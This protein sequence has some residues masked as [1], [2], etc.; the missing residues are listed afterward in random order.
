VWPY[1]ELH[2]A[3]KTPTT[4]FEE[5][6]RLAA[7]AALVGELDAVNVRY[8]TALHLAVIVD[9]P[10]VV[11]QLVARGAS[12][13]RQEQRH[14]D[15]VLHLACRLGRSTCLLAVYEALRWTTQTAKSDHIKDVLSSINYEGI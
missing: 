10:D 7:A 12:L 5:I 14:G 8:Q 3:I 13:R 2:R 6:D 1:R 9:R 11:T 4:R 15:S